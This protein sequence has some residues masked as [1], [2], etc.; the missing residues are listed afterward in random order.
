MPFKRV[1]LVKPSGRHGLSYA[2]DLIPTALEYIAATVEDIVDNVTV[3]D[4]EMEDM[5]FEEAVNES[6]M[7]LDP[8][9]VGITMS[10]TE[11]SEG[12]EIARLA[13][14]Q[15]ALTVLG[16]YHPTAIPD[17]LLSH[18]QVD[19]IVR[20][21]G[22]I[23]MREL[24]KKGGPQ[25]VRGVSYREKRQ[26][27]HNPDREFIENLDSL[28]FPARHLRR[29]AYGTRLLRDREYDVLTASRGCFGRCTFCCEPTMS[30]GHQRFRSPAKVMEEILEIVA[31]HDHK[32]I[33][34][35]VTDPHFMGS[36]ERVEQLCDLLA[37]HELDIRFGVKVRADSMAKHPDIV[38]KMIAVGIEGFEM[39]IESPNMEDIKSI[40]KGMTTDVHIQAVNNIKRWGGNAGGTFV[41]GLPDQ[42]EDQILEFPTYAKRIGLTSTA[43][44]IATPF[45]G[46]RFYE[47]LDAQGRIF[48]TDWNRYDE[49]HSIFKSKHV[50][51]ERIEEL[52]S[53][54]M[55]R[56]W[57][58]D[59]FIEKERMH[60]IRHASKRSLA[61]FI[62][63]KIQELSFSI[64]M[65]SQ[66]Q[67]KNLGNHVLA[68]IEASADPGVEGYT[69]EVGVH[70]II[71]MTRFLRL[72]GIQTVQLTVMN[73]GTAITSWILK[74]KRDGVEYIQVIPGKSDMN[75]INLDIDLNHFEFG[76]SR[77]LNIIDNIR[78]LGKMLASNRGIKKQPNMMRL[79]MAGGLELAVGRL[80][81]T[82]RKG[83][84]QFCVS[85]LG[86]A[87]DIRLERT[88]PIGEG[89]V[90]SEAGPKL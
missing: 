37:Q 47:D 29:Y 59:M 74:T 2:F 64:E 31:F 8:D 80:R 65:G 44:G 15:G 84:G 62:D 9:L 32:P 13:K 45:P 36:P 54:C 30:K 60:L 1:L 18:S 82:D 49:M 38:R 71:D 5:P 17:E 27:I 41:I 88:S 68:V 50:S 70:D 67:N 14:S 55:A 86:C 43:Y 61:R 89:E 85:S 76:G 66:L 77:S 35:D 33:S 42:T 12:L 63:E 28:P 3:L 79:L 57:T 58:A 6:L 56:F 20:G 11:H 26:I 24:V 25:G 69:R 48:E 4:L 90:V 16:G 52:A 73:N 39:G 72:L 78:I 22:E 53:I 83:N 21:E 34:I 40:S 19:L 46:T 10:A 51:S 7:A 81:T 75:T 87:N 23:T